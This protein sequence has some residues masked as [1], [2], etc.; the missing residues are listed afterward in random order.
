VLLEQLKPH[1]MLQ[2]ERII[3]PVL[4]PLCQKAPDCSP[5]NLTGHVTHHHHTGTLTFQSS[6]GLL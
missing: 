6:K 5:G 2:V 4:W 3:K 1:I